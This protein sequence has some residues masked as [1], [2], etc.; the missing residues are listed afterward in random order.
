MTDQTLTDLKCCTVCEFAVEMPRIYITGDSFCAYRTDPDQHWPARLAKNL[1]LT[2]EGRGYPGQGWWPSCQDFNWYIGSRKFSETSV[3]VFCH[4][5]LNRPITNNEY[6]KSGLT[7]EQ[8]EFYF[9]Y[10]HDPAVNQWSANK[11][12]REIATSL[13]NKTV[14]HLHFGSSNQKL[15]SQ[16]PGKHLTPELVTMTSW[17]S[18][19]NT[20]LL[21]MHEGYPNHFTPKVNAKLADLIAAKWQHNVIDIAK[22][23]LE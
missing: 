8:Q 15:R 10:L 9:R 7:E 21:Q 14:L 12:Y 18:N 1:G 22:G 13:I 19:G 3:F 6:C 16:L 5:D 11:W 20:G 2:L 4:T 17:F 23:E